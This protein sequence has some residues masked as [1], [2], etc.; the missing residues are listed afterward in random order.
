MKLLKETAP[1]GMYVLD[2]VH[3][4]GDEVIA[5]AFTPNWVTGQPHAKYDMSKQCWELE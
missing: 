4:V 5:N 2:S 1:D 3:F